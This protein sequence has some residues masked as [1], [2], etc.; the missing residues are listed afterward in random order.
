METVADLLHLAT[1][2][3]TKFR[4]DLVTQGSQ[5]GAERAGHHDS[6]AQHTV[7]DNVQDAAVDVTKRGLSSG[8]G[9]TITCPPHSLGCR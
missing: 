8:G 4:D 7:S 2:M 5:A 9:R 3:G 1:S 6:S